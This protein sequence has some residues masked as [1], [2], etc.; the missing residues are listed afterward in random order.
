[1]HKKEFLK[2]DWKQLLGVL[3]VMIGFQ[4]AFYA[5]WELFSKNFSSSSLKLQNQSRFDLASLKEKNELP[6]QWNSIRRVNIEGVNSVTSRWAK[7]IDL[8]VPTD[9]NGKYSLNV[10]IIPIEGSRRSAII[11]YDIHDYETNELL[12]EFGRTLEF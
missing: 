2:F 5:S 8:K 11:Q 6:E 3:V 12:F 7:K 1:M 9:G 4:M 10:L